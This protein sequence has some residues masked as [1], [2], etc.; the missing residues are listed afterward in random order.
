MSEE[1]LKYMSDL[2]KS[3]EIP[4]AFMEWKSDAKQT[5][6]TGEYQEVG[7]L[8]LEEDGEQE[9][10]FILNGFSRAS[11]YDLEKAKNRL[12]RNLPQTATLEKSVV[13]VFYGSSFP[14]PTGDAKLKRIQINLTIKEWMVNES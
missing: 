1:A 2:L 10:T 9:T 14:V 11:Q 7:S 8:T 12:K 13:A 3:L 5:Y 4:Y 6:F